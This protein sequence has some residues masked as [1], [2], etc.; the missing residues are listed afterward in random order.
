MLIGFVDDTE[1]QVTS[2]S[3]Q[4]DI[5]AFGGY[6]IELGSLESFQC[7]IAEVK[8]QYGLQAMHPLKWNL[9]DPKLRRYYEDRGSTSDVT[10]HAS[11]GVR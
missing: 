3:T 4:P 8:V 10:A 11:D 5:Y 9:R 7:R 6:F 2:D 1:I